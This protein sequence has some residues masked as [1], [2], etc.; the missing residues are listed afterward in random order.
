MEEVIA[1]AGEGSGSDRTRLEPE[2]R[3]RALREPDP[4]DEGSAESFPASD[5][6]SGT[7]PA[8]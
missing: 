2:R 5:P 8:E 1:G 4:V 7:S 6:P 3:E